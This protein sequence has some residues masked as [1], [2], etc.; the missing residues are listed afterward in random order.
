MYA[1]SRKPTQHQRPIQ[2]DAFLL[3]FQKINGSRQ[4]YIAD[5][6]PF[7]LLLVKRA[8]VKVLVHHR[9]RKA[10]NH[11]QNTEHTRILSVVV[12]SVQGRG[13][14]GEVK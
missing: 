1:F 10:N 6:Q 3:E 9:G 2:R 4:E 13:A 14:K 7:F 5:R 8:V 11:Q 12:V